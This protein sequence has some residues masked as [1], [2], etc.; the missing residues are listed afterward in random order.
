MFMQILL[1]FCFWLCIIPAI[2]EFSCP[3]S[4]LFCCVGECVWLL[5]QNSNAN[6]QAGIEELY[7]SKRVPPPSSNPKWHMNTPE[8]NIRQSVGRRRKP[9]IGR[10]AGTM[11][12]LKR[13]VAGLPLFP[14]FPQRINYLIFVFSISSFLLFYVHCANGNV[15]WKIKMF[16]FAKIVF[17]E[18]K[19]IV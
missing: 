16:Y 6:I 3:Q 15:K 4:V 10:N 11:L 9:A 13:F 1:R 8:H 5:R 7:G 17:R 19:G 12:S 2:Y 18:L 14:P